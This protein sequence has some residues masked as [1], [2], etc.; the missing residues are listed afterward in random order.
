MTPPA[1]T[2]GTPSSTDSAN[3]EASAGSDSSA[4]SAAGSGGPAGSGSGGSRFGRARSGGA[5]R[6]PERPAPPQ[7]RGLYGRQPRDTEPADPR[8]VK[9]AGL[10]I[11]VGAVGAAIGLFTPPAFYYIPA[12]LAV[13]TIVLVILAWPARPRVWIALLLAGLALAEAIYGYSA[14]TQVHNF[15]TPAAHATP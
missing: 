5:V 8:K 14:T 6:R 3:P 1:D 13:A 10:G 12:A 15:E 2:P 7:R 9:V 4:G 11:L